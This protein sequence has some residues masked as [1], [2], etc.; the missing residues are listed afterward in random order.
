MDTVYYLALIGAYDV[1]VDEVEE[2]D[3]T[4]DSSEPRENGNEEGP[5]SG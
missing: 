2:G 1:G 4:I 3:G 5:K